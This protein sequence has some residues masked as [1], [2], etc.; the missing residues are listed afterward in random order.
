MAEEKTYLELS[1][2]GGGSHKFYEV[3]VNG[4]ELTIRYGRIGDTG[5][6]STKE[7]ATEEKAQAEA[8]KKINSKVKKGYEHAVIGVRKKRAVTRRVIESKKSEAKQSRLLAS[9]WEDRKSVV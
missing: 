4:K 9:H 5:R 6:I 1:Q 8:K 2:E 3:T 7:L